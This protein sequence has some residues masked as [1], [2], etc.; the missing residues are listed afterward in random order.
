MSAGSMD[1]REF[2]GVNEV[3]KP[4]EKKPYYEVK[5]KVVVHG[6]HIDVT[7]VTDMRNNLPVFPVR[8]YVVSHNHSSYVHERVWHL[9]DGTYKI[10][11]ILNDKTHVKIIEVR[12]GEARVIREYTTD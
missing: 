11:R 8:I 7:A 10:A 3:E 4:R 6:K 2:I 5:A 12:N 1:M 9:Y